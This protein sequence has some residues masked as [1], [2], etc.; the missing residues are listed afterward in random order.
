MEQESFESALENSI[1]KYVDEL[2]KEE[3]P[4]DNLLPLAARRE[5]LIHEVRESLDQGDLESHVATAVSIFMNEGQRYLSNQEYAGLAKDIDDLRTR[6]KSV[7]PRSIDENKIKAIYAISPQSL[8]SIFKIGLAKFNEGSLP[9]CLSIFTFLTTIK[10]D[11]A[12]YKYRLGLIAQKN[13]C[14]DVALRAYTDATKLDPQLIGAHIFASECH[15]IKGHKEAAVKELNEAKDIFN[16]YDVDQGWKD[17][18]SNM[19]TLLAA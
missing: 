15:L 18:I 10:S 17:Q 4:A 19:E 5:K 7:D 12:D 11:D 6:V 2:L 3:H 8:D 13:A 1:Q 14:Y 9:E 16:K